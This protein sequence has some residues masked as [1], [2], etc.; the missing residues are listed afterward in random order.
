MTNLES[1][2][3]NAEI[4]LGRIKLV[5]NNTGQEKEV[6]NVEDLNDEE[7]EMPDSVRTVWKLFA[8]L[9]LKLSQLL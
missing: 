9:T 7:H 4:G 2:Y 1:G 5:K 8:L 6:C 3:F